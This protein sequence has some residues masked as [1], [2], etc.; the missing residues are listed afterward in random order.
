VED[1]FRAGLLWKEEPV[2][3][4]K[5]RQG[6]YPGGNQ[7]SVMGESGWVRVNWDFAKGFGKVWAF[8]KRRAGG[9]VIRHSGKKSLGGC[10]REWERQSAENTDK[11]GLSNQT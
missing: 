5:T 9:G 10:G 6:I 8:L 3:G 1:P 11:A 7:K 4:E 2:A